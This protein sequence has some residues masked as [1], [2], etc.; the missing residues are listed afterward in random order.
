MMRIPLSRPSLGEEEKEAVLAVLESGFLSL[1]EQHATFERE[2][3]EYL[4]VPYAVSCN[5]GTSALHMAMLI[6]GIGPGDEVI[7]TPFS[8][9]ASSNCILMVGATPV[10]VDIDPHTYNLDVSQI[11]ARITP[12]TKAI[13]PVHVFGYPA[14]MN[15]ILD[16][17]RRYDLRVVE[18]AC[19]A[20]GST[21]DG[22]KVG[23]IGDLAAF[24][25]YPNK[26]M[27]TGE[28]GML[29]TRS[30]EWAELARSLRNQGRGK[31]GVWLVHERLGFNYRLDEMSAAV[32]LAQLRKLDRLLAKRA[33]VARWYDDR[34][35]E[36]PDVVLPPRPAGERMSWFV[37]VV[38]FANQQQRDRV[39]EGLLANGIGCRPYFSPI[40]LQPF[41]RQRFGYRP[42]DFPVTERVARTALALPFFAD[43]R[44]DEVEYVV[45]RIKRYL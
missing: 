27:T 24:G 20:L 12:R 14:N 2:F 22:K 1:G 25:F 44:E 42:G 37:Y 31:E 19:E 23:T 16:L 34:L 41:Y 26:Q 39:M 6:L 29:V 32:G 35:R 13:L 38:R 7:T 15:A 8:F 18:D 36:L 30:A 28:G 17:A 45:E 40:H 10:F 11:E 33:Q 4:G 3:A 5:S 21:Y 9:I 43:L